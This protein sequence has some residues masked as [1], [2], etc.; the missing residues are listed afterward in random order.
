MDTIE[1]SLRTLK[2]NRQKWIYFALS[3]SI[4]ALVLLPTLWYA[5]GPDHG[6]CAY[7]AWI[8]RRFG[9]L[10]YVNY[11]EGDF[12]GIFLI[13]YFIQAVLGESVTGF[14]AFDL[15][16][17]TATA[18][19]LYLITERA[20]RK[21]MAGLIASLLYAIFYLGLGFWN[22]GERD[23]FLL[24]PCA[25][26]FWLYFRRAPGRAPAWQA[27]LAG[28]LFGFAFL[29][30]PVAALPG[31]IFAGILLKFS[32]AKTLSLLTYVF[33]AGLP[34]LSF[35]AWYWRMGHLA[36]M[37]EVVFVFGSE[38]YANTLLVSLP[39]FLQGIVLL[40][41]F[42]VAPMIAV[43]L[44]LFPVFGRGLEP[45][46]KSNAKILFIFAAGFFMG[47]LV[48]GKYFVYQQTP[49][50]AL[51]CVFAGAGFALAVDRFKLS[52]PAWSPAA[53]LLVVIVS[54]LVLL[55]KP[56]QRAFFGHA[57]RESPARGQEHFNFFRSC[58]TA[59][60]Y[61]EAHTAQ[62]QKVQVWGTD[63]LIN[64]LSGRQCPT[65]FAQ[66]FPL[67]LIP[68]PETKE[69]SPLQKELGREFLDAIRKDPPEYFLVETISHPGF[70]IESS[71]KILTDDYPEI[72][73]FVRD[74]YE[75]EYAVPFFD[76]AIEFYRLK[77]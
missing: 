56:E 49:A 6:M 43:G 64:Y 57:L 47:Y 68:D 58:K 53:A 22:T 12:P 27:A 13:Y 3:I 17:Q 46:V 19:F 37:I 62:D 77:K 73:S 9:Q 7:A 26:A 29:V 48:Q 31:L 75:P 65:R 15:I 76:G 41:S 60:R 32:R 40:K 25:A 63:G 28:L 51:L 14:R 20:F 8:W 44:L 18:A 38:V 74:K 45:P 36:K 59:A 16:W 39:Y 70:G 35:L 52:R 5:F 66:I 30:K 23:G 24:L 33:F 42:A 11:F 72:W 50:T 55:A 34:F 1:S 69:R 21:P 61:L 2:A 71:K 54:A 4:S 67:A 10:P